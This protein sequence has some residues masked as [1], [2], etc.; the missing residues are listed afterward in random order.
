M[1]A[2]MSDVELLQVEIEALR[3]EVATWEGLH[4]SEVQVRQRWQA[5]ADRLAGALRDAADD[6]ERGIDARIVVAQAR[7]ALDQEGG[8]G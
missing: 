3:A 4:A 1:A 2:P 7:A 6:L 8:N 5:R